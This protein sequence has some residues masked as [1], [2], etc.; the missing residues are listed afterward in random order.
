MNLED[1]LGN[2]SRVLLDTA[3]II[4]YLEANPR[5]VNLMDR[6][7]LLQE[8]REIQLVTSPVTLAECLIFPLRNSQVSLVEM[9]SQFLTQGQRI[10]FH[11]IE[12][13]EALIASEIRA[14]SNLTL[15]DAFQIAVALQSNCQ[16]ILTNDYAFRR[17]DR[18]RTIVLDDLIQ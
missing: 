9:Y 3:P 10:V 12:Q 4:Y 11:P 13:N 18:I 16:A 2:V 6:F 15:S 8:E 5:Y 7:F 1:G 14:E 17:V